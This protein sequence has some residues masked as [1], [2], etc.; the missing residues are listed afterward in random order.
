MCIGYNDINESC[1]KPAPALHIIS[2]RPNYASHSAFLTFLKPTVHTIVPLLPP[3]E[4]EGCWTR[5]LNDIDTV[6]R[7]CEYSMEKRCWVLG[8]EWRRG[9]LVFETCF[10]GGEAGND[11][12]F[13]KVARYA[14]KPV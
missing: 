6:Q 2:S 10:G 14:Q 13:S 4:K 9:L 11:L 5:E 1:I 8:R 3:K 12:R 7:L